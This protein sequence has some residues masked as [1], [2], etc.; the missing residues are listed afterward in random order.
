MGFEDDMIEDGFHDEQDYLEYISSEEYLNRFASGS[1]N[2]SEDNYYDDYSAESNNNKK[3]NNVSQYEEDQFIGSVIS[4]NLDTI[5][6]YIRRKFNIDYLTTHREFSYSFFEG[7]FHHKW[8]RDEIGR[9]ALHIACKYGH[10]EIVKYL[11]QHGADINKFTESSFSEQDEHPYN[12][13]LPFYG[14]YTDVNRGLTPLH[15]ATK[16][17]HFNVVKYL[18]E[19]GADINLCY[20]DSDWTAF[21]IACNYGYKNIVKYLISKGENVNCVKNSNGMAP[22]HIACAAGQ[23]SIVHLL[24]NNG[25]DVNIDAAMEEGVI[26]Y[27]LREN[28]IDIVKF[29]IEDCN[30]NANYEDNIE[31]LAY[32]ILRE[33]QERD[34]Y[35]LIKCDDGLYRS[36]DKIEKCV[37]YISNKGY[38]EIMNYL[39]MMKKIE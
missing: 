28:H 31:S 15:I 13:H 30:A 37:E 3:D 26:Y 21:Y 38:K 4:G 9:T 16:Y 8:L 20:Y 7:E 25:A 34:L 2:D 11:V 17:G 33:H 24:V 36:F 39:R 6:E 1:D 27:A 5:K 12:R 32:E 18:V 35:P 29:L 19:H 10:L 22:L 14:G 23:L